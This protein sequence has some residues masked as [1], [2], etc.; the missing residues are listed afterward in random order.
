MFKQV[1]II[2]FRRDYL[3]QYNETPQTP[4]EKIESIDMLRTIETGGKILMVPMSHETLSIDT[5]YDLERV[6]EAMKSDCLRE[7]YEN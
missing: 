4:M 3:L 6:K 7:K 5:P 2:P 1:C